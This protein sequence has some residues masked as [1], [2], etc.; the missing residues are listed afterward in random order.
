MRCR[1]SNAT[2]ISIIVLEV[3]ALL[4]EMLGAAARPA[5]AAGRGSLKDKYSTL[6]FEHKGSLLSTRT[7]ASKVQQFTQASS[8]TQHRTEQGAHCLIF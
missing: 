4:V 1:R 3:V 8:V 6:S 2:V 7:S 5:P